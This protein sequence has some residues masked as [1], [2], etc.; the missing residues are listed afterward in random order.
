MSIS[1]LIIRICCIPPFLL[2]D[3]SSNFNQGT[4]HR[5]AFSTP[6][7]DSNNHVLILHR[8]SSVQM[9]S[10]TVRHLS[11]RSH[12]SDEKLLHSQ[13]R[14]VSSAPL[15]EVSRF[16]A[17]LLLFSS[18]FA[19][20][21]KMVGLCLHMDYWALYNVDLCVYVHTI[22]YNTGLPIHQDGLGISKNRHWCPDDW[23]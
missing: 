20:F 10:F 3:F 1:I 18:A 6:F 7:R 4:L 5:L 14:I 15:W 19:P 13:R 2:L 17:T 23:T 8:A 16:I 12:L 9:V 11:C 21:H 22:Q